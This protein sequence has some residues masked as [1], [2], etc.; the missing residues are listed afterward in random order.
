MFSFTISFHTKFPFSQYPKSIIIVLLVEVTTSP[1]S[2]SYSTSSES[3]WCKPFIDEAEQASAGY[4]ASQGS[5]MGRG[6]CEVLSD[7]NKE[8]V[9]I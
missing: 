8:I 2:R 6:S 9:P 1:S 3:F 7:A 4:C 5:T